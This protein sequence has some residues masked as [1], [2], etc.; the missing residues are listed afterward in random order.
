MP[1]LLAV[2]LGV[3]LVSC[4]EWNSASG[5]AVYEAHVVR[6]IETGERAFTGQP[7]QP[8]QTLALQLD[9]GLYRGDVVEVQWGGRNALNYNGVL[10]EGDRVLVSAQL[11]EGG[12]LYVIEEIQRFPSLAPFLLALALA[13]VVVARRKGLASLVGLAGSVGVYLLVVIPSIRA[14][15]D[16]FAATLAAS[17]AVLVVAVYVVHGLNR[18]STAALLGAAGGLAVVALL[19]TIGLSLTHLTGL[20]SEEEVY[21]AVATAGRID[22]PKLLLAGM[23]VGSLGALVDMSVGQAST[24]FELAAAHHEFRGRRLWT[25]ALNVGHDHIGSLVNTLA[26]A[27]FGGALPLAVLLSLGN[28]PVAL[29]LN[30]ETIVLSLLTVLV[31]S[32]GLVLCVPLTTAVAVRL[33]RD[34]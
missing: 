29:G 13:L 25:S 4:A 15:T 26:L 9:S 8:F 18:K 12:R 11:V 2:L 6:V 27:Y 30:S 31:A 24:T 16:P 34:G 7:P 28:A 23:V 1:R 32:V 3:V 33:V 10:R 21:L 17:L 19:A 14:G 20:G 22:M 5:G